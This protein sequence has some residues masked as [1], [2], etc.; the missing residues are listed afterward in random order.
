MIFI[1]V[2]VSVSALGSLKR[3]EARF[4]DFSLSDISTFEYQTSNFVF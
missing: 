2:Y 1:S 4:V 3:S